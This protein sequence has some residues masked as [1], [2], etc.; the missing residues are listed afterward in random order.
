MD[1]T[2][3]YPDGHGGGC[4]TQPETCGKLDDLEN[5]LKPGPSEM[6]DLH[7]GELANRDLDSEIWESQEAS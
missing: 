4:R 7:E 2:L 6:V 5:Q 3:Q 1:L